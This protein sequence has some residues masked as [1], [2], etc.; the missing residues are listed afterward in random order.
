[1]N[2]FINFIKCNLNLKGFTLLRTTQNKAIIFKTFN[3]YTVCIYIKVVDKYIEISVDKI[4]D[5]KYSYKGIERLLISK[6][7]FNNFN[8][9]LNYIKKNIAIY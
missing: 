4:F 6:N 2:S 1:M 7:S 5:D 9:C 3:R 8:D